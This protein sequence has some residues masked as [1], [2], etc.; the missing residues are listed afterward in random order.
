MTGGQLYL[1]DGAERLPLRLNEQLVSAA[2][3]SADELAFVRELIERHE[4]YTGSSR[5]AALLA[6]WA[7]ELHRWWRV[8]PK[9]EVAELQSV[10]E[11]TAG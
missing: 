8:A 10:Y 7:T 4:R 5:A 1:Y 11:G 3:P 2:R 6:R 9:G